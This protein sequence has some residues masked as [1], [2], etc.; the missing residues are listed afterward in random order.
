MPKS[1]GRSNSRPSALVVAPDVAP[2]V[3]IVI[4]GHHA[5]GV[6]QEVYE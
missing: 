1:R 6:L 4:Q 5:L 3:M 2:N